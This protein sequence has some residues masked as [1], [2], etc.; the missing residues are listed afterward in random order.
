ML[1][2]VA[3]ELVL[4]LHLGFIG[5]MITGGVAVRWWPRI[6]WLHGPMFVWGSVVNLTHWV[7]P[8]TPLENHLR[9]LAGESGYPGTFIEQYIAPVVYP[10]GM[11]GDLALA[12]GLSLLVW[13]VAV[14]AWAFRHRPW[15]S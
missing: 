2:Q 4:T 3:A 12:T 9:Q 13:N 5:F 15:R 14:Y 11:T 10:A 1:Y 7:C 6:A 8:L